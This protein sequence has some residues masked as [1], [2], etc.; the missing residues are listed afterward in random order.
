MPKLPR[1]FVGGDW[2]ADGLVSTA[3]IVYSQEKLG[4]YP[5]KGRVF[6]DKKPVD[7]ERLKFIL[8]DIRIPYDMVI[9]LDVPYTETVPRI[10]WMLKHHFG[11]K[12]IM[13]VDHHLST[14]TNAKKLEEI[15]DEL[16]IDRRKPTALILHDILEERGIRIT[17]RLKAF[18]EV[19]GYMDT[20]RRVPD[21]YMKLFE[22]ASLFSKAFNVVRDEKIWLRIVDWL[23]SPT[24]LAT[25]M[26][27]KI[28]RKLKEVV[29]K[30][31]EEVKQL[32]LDLAMGA[33]KVGSFRFIDARNKWKYRGGTALASKIHA[34]LKAPVALLVDT[35]KE[36]T[37]LIVKAPRGTAFRVAKYFMGNGLALD[38][39]GHPNLA[40]IKLPKN[41]DIN[42][43]LEA[44]LQAQYYF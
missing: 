9:L 11:V 37:L 13:Y 43:I 30:R 16:I 40:I 36:Y 24:P 32:A 7:P 14:Q 35:S 25:P 19:V 4:E 10:L 2:D 23:A 5:I 41:P 31:D 1:V 28:I 29:D 15:V 12:K 33:R 21:K 22:I 38:I 39:A 18:V 3:L 8:S 17:E 27:E 34:I 20:G 26:D 44:L 42:E 6:L